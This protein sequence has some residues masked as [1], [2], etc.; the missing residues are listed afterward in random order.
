M[1]SEAGVLDIPA[2]QIVQ[3]GRLQPGRMFLVD[4]EQGR[5]IEDEEIK[6]EV[7]RAQPYR[8]WLNEHLVHLDKLPERR[9]SRS[10]ITRRCSSAR[11][12][13]ATRSRTSA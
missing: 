1:A 12:R 3:K 6:R 5:I 7:A 2:D 11:S 9:P 4:T 13:L 10:P 8:A